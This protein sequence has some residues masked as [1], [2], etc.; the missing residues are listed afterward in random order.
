MIEG[1]AKAHLKN[2]FNDNQFIDLFICQDLVREC[3]IQSRVYFFKADIFE[4][5]NVA[6]KT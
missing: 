6:I 2:T 5:Q 1:C 4:N 3:R